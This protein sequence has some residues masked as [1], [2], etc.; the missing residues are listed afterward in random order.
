MG[1]S[2]TRTA[3]RSLCFITCVSAHSSFF[4]ST[5]P[6]PVVREEALRQRRQSSFQEVERRIDE[7]HGTPDPEVFDDAEH[8]DYCSR[9]AP[10]IY[11]GQKYTDKA[12]CESPSTTPSA[13]STTPSAA[14]GKIEKIAK[15]PLGEAEGENDLKPQE[16]Q[17]F[18]FAKAEKVLKGIQ[19]RLSIINEASDENRATIDNHRGQI[20]DQRTA[21]E[22]FVT[23][24]NQELEILR[25]GMK[26][27]NQGAEIISKIADRYKPKGPGFLETESGAFI[28]L[29]TALGVDGC[30]AI[31]SG[32]GEAAAV[33]AAADAIQNDQVPNDDSACENRKGATPDSDPDVWCLCNINKLKVIRDRDSCNTKSGGK[34]DHCEWSDDENKCLP[35]AKT[36]APAVDCS[37]WDHTFDEDK[38]CLKAGCSYTK[39]GHGQGKDKCEP[40]PA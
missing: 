10:H 32:E 23:K 28:D 1:T 26:C 22:T 14:S 6:R 16:E 39:N 5:E 33:A 40:R 15:L 2:R 21:F 20:K 31:G 24:L 29:G 36:E 25:K 7:K 13:A 17:D 18:E 19:E 3:F 12:S 34:G 11:K 8:L 27:I 4:W 35:R 30:G 9:D 37:Q 38:E